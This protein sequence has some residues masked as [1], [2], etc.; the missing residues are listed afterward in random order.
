[1]H[2]RAFFGNQRNVN[3]TYSLPDTLQRG[4]RACDQLRINLVVNRLKHHIKTNID[5]KKV[6]EKKTTV[7]R[8]S[9]WIL[10]N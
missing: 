3:G 10:R 2:G 9:F 7:D 1:M 6:N 5:Y 4:K 8:Q